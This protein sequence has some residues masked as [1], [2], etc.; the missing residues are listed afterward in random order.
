[1]KTLHWTIERIARETGHDR[2]T[3]ASKMAGQSADV[4][5]RFTTRQVIAGMFGDLH[6][7]RLRE[8]RSRADLNELELA[9]KERKLV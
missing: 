4:K 1:M 8:V 7:E 2:K 9:R 5:G 3:V 6:N